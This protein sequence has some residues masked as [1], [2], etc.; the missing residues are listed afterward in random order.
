MKILETWIAM[1]IDNAQVENHILLRKVQP[2]NIFAA[3]FTHRLIFNLNKFSAS[4][5][6]ID[7]ITHAINITCIHVCGASTTSYNGKQLVYCKGQ[8]AYSKTWYKINTFYC[9]LL[10]WRILKIKT[11]L[12]L[13][14]LLCIKM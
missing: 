11:I 2:C 12:Y 5:F 14:I 9:D 3:Y 7:C 6:R 4:I 8:S 1:F 10:F 13:H